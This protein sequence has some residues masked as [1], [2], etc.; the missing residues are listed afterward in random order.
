[1]QWSVEWLRT[2]PRMLSYDTKKAKKAQELS[3][4]FN[5]KIYRKS[6]KTV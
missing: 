4:L 5:L 6:Y 3:L 1:M 2:L